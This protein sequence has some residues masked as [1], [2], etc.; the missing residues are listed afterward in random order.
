MHRDATSESGSSDCISE[1]H[2]TPFTPVL[3]TENLRRDHPGQ[4]TGALDARGHVT[5]WLLKLKHFADASL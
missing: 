3:N 4:V 2:W 5:D 1:I